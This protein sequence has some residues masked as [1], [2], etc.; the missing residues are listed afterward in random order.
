[1]EIYYELKRF[2]TLNIKINRIF[3]LNSKYIDQ[4]I[5]IFEFASDDCVLLNFSSGNSYPLPAADLYIS[6]LIK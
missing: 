2:L 4:F 1:M 6:L 5:F 3:I